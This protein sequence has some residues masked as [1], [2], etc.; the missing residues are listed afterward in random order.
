[1]STM[2]N[3]KPGRTWTG[4]PRTRHRASI[5]RAGSRTSADDVPPVA[6]PSAAAMRTLRLR[7]RPQA[8]PPA[9]GVQ[10]PPRRQG[11]QPRRDDERA[12]AARAARA[13][14]SPPTPAGR[15]CTA[16][17]PAGLDDEIAAHVAKLERRWAASLGDPTDPLLVSVRSGAKFSMPGM[18]DTVLNLGPQR[19]EREGPRRGDRR[20]AL[21]L[22]LLPPLHLDV[23]PH[24]ARHRRRP[25]RAPAGGGQG[26][27]RRRPPTPRSRP[28]R[29][30]SCARST[31]R[32]SRRP[33]ASR[34]RR[35]R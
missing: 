14:R 25:L 21:R 30:R 33:P 1:M 10:G 24:R 28:P 15:T 18:M 2:K 6:P 8:P 11:R 22:R 9:D 13:S 34:S 3:R 5:V 20:R 17:W 29:S 12:E 27:R 23:R 16:G 31:R 19:Q 4:K 26:G 32:S 35:T 7:L